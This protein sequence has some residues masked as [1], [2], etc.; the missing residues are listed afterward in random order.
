MCFI[1][2]FRD[3]FQAYCGTARAQLSSYILSAQPDIISEVIF[4]LRVTLAPLDKDCTVTVAPEENEVSHASQIYVGIQS[5]VPLPR[6]GGGM[7]IFQLK[8]GGTLY[9][10][11]A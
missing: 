1:C 6:H 5:I 4:S 7:R 2:S 9:T 8:A 3:F 11:T 10:T